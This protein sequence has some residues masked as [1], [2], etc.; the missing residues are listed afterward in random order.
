MT[1]LDRIADRVADALFRLFAR[2][3][4]DDLRAAGAPSAPSDSPSC[5]HGSR[6]PV[7]LSEHAS[8]TGHA[9]PPDG[10]RERVHQVMDEVHGSAARQPHRALGKGPGGAGGQQT[11]AAHA[12]QDPAVD[13]PNRPTSNGVQAQT[14]RG[15]T[16]RRRRHA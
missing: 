5:G 8:P 4:D 11:D 9:D 2:D 12:G 7:G 3:V 13:P 15:G 14:H 6:P 1:S 16:A 10:W